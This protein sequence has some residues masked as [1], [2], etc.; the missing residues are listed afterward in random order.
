M[1][2]GVSDLK[3]HD[4]QDL[5]REDFLSRWYGEHYDE[6]AYSG[7]ASRVQALMHRSLERGYNH[8]TIFARTLELGGNRGEHLSYVRHSYDTYLLTDLKIPLEGSRIEATPWGKVEFS[9]AD[10]QNLPFENASFNRVV[11]SC[12]L[13]HVPQ[14]EDALDEVRRVLVPGGTADLFLSG[15]PGLLFRM[16]RGVGPARAAR[17]RGLGEV[18]RLVDARDHV[19]HVG[20]LRRLIQHVFREDSVQERRYPLGLPGWNLSLWHTFRIKKQAFD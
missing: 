9:M 12:L 6:N 15:D 1:R 11:H 3:S 7:I 8:E 18:K 20:A 4:W 10:A 5:D 16:A 17:R 19:N 13:H 14:P 2:A